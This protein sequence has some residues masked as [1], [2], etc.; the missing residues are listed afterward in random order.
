M[1]CNLG[2]HRC[3]EVHPVLKKQPMIGCSAA[4]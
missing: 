2:L 1:P 3:Y 4:Q